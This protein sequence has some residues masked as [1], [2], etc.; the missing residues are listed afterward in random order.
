[1]PTRRKK[2]DGAVRQKSVGPNQDGPCAA[3]PERP[4]SARPP[5]PSHTISRRSEA[6]SRVRSIR[7]P[8]AAPANTKPAQGKSEK[9]V[10]PANG[11]R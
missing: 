2:N 5:T 9:V 4:H 8:T 1:M 11:R 6:A 7:T 10:R 3:I